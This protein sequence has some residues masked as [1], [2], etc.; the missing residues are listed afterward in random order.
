[1]TAL[2]RRL[3]TLQSLA[4]APKPSRGSRYLAHLLQMAALARQRRHL[5]ELPDHLLK[6]V[7]IAPDDAC[8]EAR[9]KAWDVPTHWRR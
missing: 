5:G 1:M 8:R 9:R 4:Q 7:G 6:D 3:I 2:A